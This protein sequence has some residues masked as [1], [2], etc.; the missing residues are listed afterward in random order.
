MGETAAAKAVEE[1]QATEAERQKHA[2]WVCAERRTL[3]VNFGA[4]YSLCTALDCRGREGPLVA[5]HSL[6][7]DAEYWLCCVALPCVNAFLAFDVV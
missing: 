1:K 6:E 7:T 5:A 2:F 4:M 3:Q